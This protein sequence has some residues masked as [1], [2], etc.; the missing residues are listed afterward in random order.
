MPVGDL[1]VAVG[2]FLELDGSPKSGSVVTVMKYI[3]YKTAPQNLVAL[4]ST[5]VKFHPNNSLIVAP[6]FLKSSQTLTLMFKSENIA[7][8][9]TQTVCKVL[10]II[11]KAPN[12]VG[13]LNITVSVRN[14]TST[15]P[16]NETEFAMVIVDPE[17]N[18][19]INITYLNITI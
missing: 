3:D 18:P 15:T 19:N 7:D 14:T 6:G 17:G 4:D 13:P 16:L 1:N 11:N 8:G 2:T 10:N 12:L 5:L 9:Y